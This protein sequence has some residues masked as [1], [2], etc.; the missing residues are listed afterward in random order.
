MRFP[1]PISAKRPLFPNHLFRPRS[2]I[3]FSARLLSSPLIEKMLQR[4][5]PAVKA[6][7]KNRI[8]AMSKFF[9]II[10]KE[11]R[12]KL[13][14]VDVGAADLGPGTDPYNALLSYDDVVVFGFEPN[15]EKCQQRNDNSGEN[16][17]YFPKFVGD[18]SN[19]TFHIMQ[20]PFTSSLYEPNDS[21]L[22]CFQRMNLPLISSE[23]VETICLDDINELDAIDFLKIDVQGAE[24]DVLR[25]ANKL[26]S[27]TLIVHTEVEFIPMYKDQPLYSDVDIFL[28]ERGFLLHRFIDI[29]SR[30]MKPMILN[31]DVFSKGSQIIYAD[32]AIFVR[33]FSNIKNLSNEEIL[34][35]SCI[36][37]DVYKSLDFVGFL[38]N[39]FDTRNNSTFLHAYLNMCNSR[40]ADSKG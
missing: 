4:Q 37:H 21:I 2:S 22:N 25:G 27:K 34:K 1:V 18:G 3:G 16:K 10:P 20:N 24:L 17:K 7:V 19:R 36:L 12:P 39:E 13:K 9:D 11:L 33:D 32:G 8:Q 23:E 5:T 29:F 30:Q 38:L 14:I 35:T 31:N 15:S 6:S 40:N 28:R 26:L